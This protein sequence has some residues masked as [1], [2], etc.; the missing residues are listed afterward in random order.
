M[1]LEGLDPT[2][3]DP[4]KMDITDRW[5]LSRLAKTISEVTESLDN[6][7]YSEPLSSLYRFFWNDFCDW[8]LEWAKPRMQDER[9]KPIAQNVLAFVLDQTLRLLHPFVPFITEGIFQKLNEIAP[10]RRLKGIA[11]S[12]EA[13]AL[14]IAQWPEGLDSIVDAEAEEQIVTVQTVIRA[15]R[16][17]RSKY[18]K[19]PS[20]KLVASANSPQEIAEVLNANSGLVCQLAGLKEFEASH[21][22][23]KPPDSAAMI[24]DQMQIYL[25]EAIDIEAEKQR[26]EKQKQQI[27]KAKKAVKAKLANENFVS[28]AKPEVVAQARDRLAEL[29]EQLKTVDKHLLELE[30][31]G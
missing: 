16:D 14:V 17:I 11:E 18:S 9:K 28:K 19:Q 20:E 3:F 13:K 2:K 31:G 4:D 7:K 21:T 29:S 23:Q 12:K 10:A 1:N 5:I 24:V 22:S 26:L 8:Y 30:N 15:I 6:F 27:E 25:H